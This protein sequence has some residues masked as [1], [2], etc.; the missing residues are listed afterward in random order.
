[1]GD[2]FKRYQYRNWYLAVHCR[3]Q[4]RFLGGCHVQSARR[5]WHHDRFT[6]SIWIGSTTCDVIQRCYR[7]IWR[8]IWLSVSLRQQIY[9]DT[10]LNSY[11]WSWWWLHGGSFCHS[12]IWRQELLRNI[13]KKRKRRQ[14]RYWGITEHKTG[15]RQKRD[16]PCLD[17]DSIVW[18]IERYW[19]FLPCWPS[20][21]SIFDQ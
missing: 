21:A 7:G 16:S 20:R 17:K 8:R 4:W 10:T 19:V 2:R 6:S 9:D 13:H 18:Y 14:H 5:E 3:S 15:T 11:G 1:M 12:L